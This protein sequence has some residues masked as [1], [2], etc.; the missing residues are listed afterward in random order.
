MPELL[1]SSKSSLG[2]L[3]NTFACRPPA[4]HGRSPAKSAFADSRPLRAGLPLLGVV[5]VATLAVLIPAF[6]KAGAHFHTLAASSGIGPVHFGRKF[7]FRLA[8]TDVPAMFADP[9]CNSVVIATRHDSHAQ[10]VQQALAASKHVFVEKP[11]CLTAEEL[12]AIEA[13]Y[14][15]ER[16]LMVGFNRRFAPL[17]ID[18]QQQV[19]RFSGPKL[20]YIP[21]T[22]VP[23][24]LI[25]GP[26][27]LARWRPPAR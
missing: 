1:I 14:T 3:L 4:A 24:Q 17:L 22:Q 13:A 26:K 10:L 11:L 23:S 27:T 25:I 15:G 7:G 21:A 12:T 16:L 9:S 20:V 18:L 5:R 19:A 8:S 2:I 6:W